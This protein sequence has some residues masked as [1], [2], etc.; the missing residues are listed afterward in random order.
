[1][2]H[3]DEKDIPVIIELLQHFDL[4]YRGKVSSIFEFPAF[5]ERPLDRSLWKSESHF[6]GY[7]GR[8][9]VC[10]EETDTFPPGFFSRLQV[11]ISRVLTQEKIHHFK[12]S[13][14][15]DALSYQCLVQISPSNSA[16]DL[17]G[18]SGKLFV[19]E[20]IQLLD[21]VQSQIAYLNREVCPTIFLDLLIPSSTDLKRHV[22]PR[23]FSIHEIVSGMSM[24]AN[25]PTGINESVADLLYLGDEE[26]QETQEGKQTKVAYIPMETILPVQ[27]LLSDGD[28]VSII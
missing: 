25:I 15:V 8:H 12:G 11:L 2:D 24:E 20:C 13:S 16:I 26:Y 4:C 21:L 10:T 6:T 22:Q 14:V 17:I 18:R 1:M 23:Y 19:Q 3:A 9:L 27:E 28:T 5:I 7:S